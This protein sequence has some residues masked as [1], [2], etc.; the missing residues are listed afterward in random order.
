[1]GIFCCPATLLSQAT[2]A[3]FQRLTIEQGLPNGEL[4]DMVQ[5][6]DGFMWMGTSDGICRYDGYTVMPLSSFT[7]RPQTAAKLNRRPLFLCRDAKKRWWTGSDWDGISVYDPALDSIRTIKKG[8]GGLCSNDISCLF[9]DAQQRVW[10]GTFDGLRVYDTRTESFLPSTSLDFTVFDGCKINALE[11]D[12][13]GNIWVATNNRGLWRFAP[14]QVHPVLVWP[15]NKNPK[16]LEISALD[17]DAEG[18]LWFATPTEVWLWTGNT[19]QS[20]FKKNIDQQG[21]DFSIVDLKNDR[22]GQIWLGTFQSGAWVIDK[23]S[24]QITIFQHETGNPFSLLN[25]QIRRITIDDSGNIWCS[26]YGEGVCI[27]P[28]SYR[29]FRQFRRPVDI[30]AANNSVRAVA[31]AA[32]GTVYAA[33]PDALLI[34]PPPYRQSEYRSLRQLGIKG[35][36][37]RVAAD[38]QKGCWLAAGSGIWHINTAHDTK[39]KIV[40][41]LPTANEYRFFALKMLGDSALCFSGNP[42]K[43]QTSNHISVFHLK[44]RTLHTENINIAESRNEAM[45]LA[46]SMHDKAGIWAG[47]YQG[48]MWIE[49]GKPAKSF[50]HFPGYYENGG[51][52]VETVWDDGQQVWWGR[53]DGG[54]LNVRRHRDGVY[55]F[56][57]KAQGLPESSVTAIVPD[58]HNRLW[59]GTY[60]GLSTF[61]KPADI[62][63]ISALQTSNYNE[64]DGIGGNNIHCGA[65][66]AGGAHLFFGTG[67]GLTH[68]RAAD[69]GN[70]PQTQLVFTQLRLFNYAV[71]PGDSTKILR[72]D[73]NQ[74]RYIQLNPTQNFFTLAFSALNFYEP[75]QNTYHYRLLGLNEDWVNNGSRNEVSFAGLRPGRY[76]LEVK[77]KGKN[78]LWSDLHAMEIE[79]LPP[80]WQRW[81]FIASLFFCGAALGFAVYR[82][83][84]RQI[85]QVQQVR[86]GIAADLHDDIGSALTNIEIMGLLG[87]KTTQQPEANHSVFEKIME[88]ARRSK[89]ALQVIVWSL[90][91]E[92]DK[93]EQLSAKMRRMAAEILEPLGITV[94]VDFPENENQR[95]NMPADQRRDILL[96]Y[97]EAL[98]NICKHAKATAVEIMLRPQDKKFLLTI[99]DNGKG[100]PEVATTYTGNGLRNIQQ[101]VLKWQGHFQAENRPEGGLLLKMEWG[102]GGG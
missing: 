60:W 94:R 99:Q 90:N 66:A 14:E 97:R 95:L 41:P 89:E 51:N 17:L 7:Q 74:T 6:E 49:T 57:L 46:P 36:L 77:A 24:G 84:I 55:N 102:V 30:K 92:N 50:S 69:F 80:L 61:P 96:A 79:V 20:M 8:A 87:Q 83:R 44:K 56:F 21:R 63:A 10:I 75:Q 26:C 18:K 34:V 43:D 62:S 54:G 76:T 81:Q 23:I 29:Y 52:A 53:A 45:S 25:N 82:W 86:Q 33:L 22:K 98:T 38:R 40:Y 1:L 65:A 42:N 68:V 73:L 70:L 101:R 16:R 2:E 28:A 15:T 35:P 11:R 9:S 72:K 88:E 39:A 59:I 31:V 3:R 58:D 71:R 67:A 47:T 85:M 64:P 27:L 48:L 100:L 5:D 19:A 78:G 93:M 37:Y 32:N 13:A 4:Y 91:D 12:T